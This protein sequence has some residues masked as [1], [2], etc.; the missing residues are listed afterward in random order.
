MKFED[1]QDIQNA[2][3]RRYDYLQ[4]FPLNIK[5][6]CIDETENLGIMETDDFLGFMMGFPV[7]EDRAGS[8]RFLIFTAEENQKIAYYRLIDPVVPWSQPILG[9]QANVVTGTHSV[10]VVMKQIGSCQLWWGDDVGRIFEAIL[11]SQIQQRMDFEAIINQ[12]WRA[13]EHELR[14]HGVSKVYTLG[15]DP[16]YD[17]VWYRRFLERQGYQAVEGKS[18]AMGKFLETR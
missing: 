11:Y 15:R 4:G 18:F 7:E 2:F 12:V 14:S 13:C 3:F 16:E 6:K 5:G 10:D 17:E 1:N 9:V 8:D